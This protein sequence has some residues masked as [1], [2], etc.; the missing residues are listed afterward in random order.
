MVG[1]PIAQIDEPTSQKPLRLWPGVVAVVLQWLFWLVLPFV[2]RDA[3]MVGMLGGVACGLA[4]LVWWLFF[5]RAPWAD[6]LGAIV[7]MVVAVI[8][9]KRVV[10][11]SIAGAGMGMLIYIYAIPALSLALVVWAVASRRLSSGLR[12][13]SMV[14]AIVLAC[15]VFTV[16]RTGGITGDADSDF[17]WRW[18]KTPEERLLAQAGD[19]PTTPTSAPAAA[20]SPEK[21]VPDAPG[22]EPAARSATHEGAETD[23]GWPGFRGPKR[24]GIIRGV[25]IETDWSRQPPVALWRR[26]C[27]HAPCIRPVCRRVCDCAVDDPDTTSARTPVTM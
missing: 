15:G 9:T 7:L 5:S 13:A 2:S 17:H 16:L 25:R 12:R 8:A 20:E 21:R 14:A 11:P 27:G 22:N 3:A 23:S 19:E 1:M 24:D 6:R 4:V 18:T 10:H 26:A